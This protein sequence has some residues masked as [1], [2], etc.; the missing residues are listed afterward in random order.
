MSKAEKNRDK[1]A[2]LRIGPIPIELISPGAVDESSNSIS[3]LLFGIGEQ[4][5]AIGVDHTEGVVEC[6]AVSPLPSPPE[7]MLGVASVRGRMT[8]VMDLSLDDKITVAKR[9]LILL[10]GDAQLGLLADRVDGVVTLEPRQLKEWS[11][12]GDRVKQGGLAPEDRWP[13]THTFRHAGRQV[14][15]IDAE[16]ISLM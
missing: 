15:I 4:L 16:G 6:P 14:P 8:L 13:A 3:V 11:V 10:K 5:F 7:G 9:R 2:T 12:E 1:K